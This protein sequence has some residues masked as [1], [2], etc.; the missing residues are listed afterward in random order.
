MFFLRCFCIITIF[1][2]L[3]ENYS[4]SQS[5]VSVDFSIEYQTIDGFG[6]H[7]SMTPWWFDGPFYND[8]YLDLLIDDFGL[9]LIRNEYYPDGGG[10]YPENSFDQ[11][12]N[13]AKQTSFL[14]ALKNKADESGEPLKYMVTLWTAPRQWKS[15][16]SHKNGGHV[17]PEY[18]DDFAQYCADIVSDYA[19]LGIDLYAIGLQNEPRFSQGFNSGVYNPE[20]FRD[21]VK[22]VGEKFEEENINTKIVGA[23]DMGSYDDSKLWFKAILEDDSLSREHLDIFAVHSYLD[24]VSPTDGSA[25]GW[26]KMFETCQQYDKP[27]WMTETSGYNNTWENGAFRLAKSVYLALKY[28]QVSGWAWWQLSEPGESV[29]VIMDLGTPSKKYYALKHFYRYI[30]PGA[31]QVETYSDDDE[32]LPISF[33]HPT[34]SI[35]S[36]I[37]INSS[38]EQK[39]IVLEMPNI[40]ENFKM[41]R[42][43][44]ELNCSYIEDLQ[45]NTL[46]LP[47][48]SVTTL[49]NKFEGSLPN[50]GKVEDVVLLMNQETHAIDLSGINSGVNNPNL[51]ISLSAYS[52]NP[53]LITDPQLEYSPNE[54]AGKLYITPNSNQHGEAI[55]KVLVTT[56]GLVDQ[57][58]FGYNKRYATFKVKVLPFVNNPPTIAI[59]DSVYEFPFSND[60][61]EIIFT[62]VGDGDDGNQHLNYT[63]E[64]SNRNTISYFNIIYNQGDDSVLIRFKPKNTGEV[65]VSLN[66]TDDGGIGLGGVDSSVNQFKIK[67]ILDQTGLDEFINTSNNSCFNNLSV[68]PNPTNGTI[69]VS[70]TCNNINSITLINKSGQIINK[71]KPGYLLSENTYDFSFLSQGVY[72]LVFESDCCSTVRKLIVK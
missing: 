11:G 69:D 63:Y 31:I 50:I 13:W 52:S 15:N 65:D 67:I 39:E 35:Y 45:G 58:G 47:P 33:I 20:Q 6:G 19:G 29:F 37:L 72:F 70:T 3:Y 54:S 40:P 30:R 48:L 44:E 2:L 34:K 61:E 17:L 26:I 23:E 1:T 64:L 57:N 55:I 8:E 71:F 49:E 16:N 46:V 22:V 5:S 12:G 42:S 62:G 9:T 24:G 4:F 25:N 59:P 21:L 27:L 38:N 14:E 41:Y 43:T 18:Y 56:D 68:Y 53:D 36:M 66:I 10:R 7:G 51:N 28:G 60:W 32:I